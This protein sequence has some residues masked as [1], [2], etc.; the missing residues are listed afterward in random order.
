MPSSQTS[1]RIA[2][3]I[4]SFDGGGV[5]TV[6][7]YAADGMARSKPWDV[8]LVNLHGPKGE[9]V[10]AASG[11]RTACLGLKVD[12]ARQFLEWLAANPQDLIITSDVARILPAFPYLPARTK[13]IVQVH[14]SLRGYRDVATR[15]LAWIDGIT[16]V[17]RHIESPLRASL[18]KARYG[19][20]LRTIHNG[21]NFPPLKPR[22][23]HN[24]PLRLLFMGRVDAFKGVFDFVPILCALKNNGVPVTLNLVGGVNDILRREFDRSGG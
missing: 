24:G 21:A 8:T 13:H 14:D 1:L 10:D 15:N 4:P 9:F 2:S 12:C 17:G 18:E 6:C 20:M 7:R 19:G 5:S 16:C 3:V 23:P 11:L 22:L